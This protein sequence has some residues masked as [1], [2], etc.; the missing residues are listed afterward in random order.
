MVL[1][2]RTARRWT[3][4]CWDAKK[5]D[6]HIEES[7]SGDPLFLLFNANVE[8]LCRQ[9]EN[10]SSRRKVLMACNKSL[11]NYYVDTCDIKYTW[12]RVIP[13]Y[14]VIERVSPIH[15]V[16]RNIQNIWN[17]DPKIC[18]LFHKYLSSIRIR[19]VE[20]K[21]EFDV[22]FEYKIVKSYI[23]MLRSSMFVMQIPKEELIFHTCRLSTIFNYVFRFIW[24]WWWGW[25]SS[26]RTINESACRFEN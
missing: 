12:W 24:G 14:P 17:C 5:V 23:E 7:N 10:I 21:D 8:E 25:Y 18:L 4:W 11:E 26:K 15:E 19:W 6:I 16:L 9:I 13:Q 20:P 1:S 2:E 22:D 3:I